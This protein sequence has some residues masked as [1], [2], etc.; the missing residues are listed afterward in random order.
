MQLLSP[1]ASVSPGQLSDLFSCTIQT[2]GIERCGAGCAAEPADIT[3]AADRR[4]E[5]VDP[6]EHG[7]FPVCQP[8]QYHGKAAAIGEAT[9]CL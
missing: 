1:S 3:P 8:R 2:G 6:D 4:R 9:K 5:A 7:P